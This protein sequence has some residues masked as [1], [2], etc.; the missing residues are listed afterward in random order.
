[1]LAKL[2]VIGGSGISHVNGLTNAEELLVETPWGPPSGH[3]VTG[4]LGQTEVVFLP[5]HGAGHVHSPAD[6]PY[7]ANI[8]AFKRLG[9]TDLISLSACGSLNEAMAP[10]DL[11]VVNQFVDRTF[12]RPTSFFGSGCVAHVS[13]AHPTCRHLAALCMAAANR[14]LPA[15]I[16]PQGT[17]L[18]MEGPQFST[19]AESRLYREHWHCDIIGMTNLPEA[20]LARE[21]EICYISVGLVT[22][23]DSWHP[24]HGEVNVTAV[25][26]TLRQNANIA[27]ELVRLICADLP[28]SRDPCPYGC[29]RTLDSAII[30]APE[31]RDPKVLA[32]LDAVAGRVLGVS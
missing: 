5:R 30:T 8:D 27:R 10:G 15:K 14:G 13:M 12:T 17:Y 2:G 4:Q 25:L 24:E 16:H 26:K 29:D 11:V 6:V 28:L 23:Y 1:M 3:F 19:L 22:D 9:V 20:R 18:A 31:Y 32:R 7:R 21:A